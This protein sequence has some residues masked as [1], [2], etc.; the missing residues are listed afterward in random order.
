MGS[1]DVHATAFNNVGWFLPPYVTLGYL[2]NMVNEINTNGESFSQIDLE[3]LLVRIYT[4]GHLSAMVAER[5]PITPYVSEFKEIISESVKAHFLGLDHLAVIGLMPVIEGAGKKLADHR[6][7][8]YSSIRSVFENLAT[9]CKNRSRQNNIGDV[10]E[11]ESMMDSFINFTKDN[12]YIN[13][14]SYLHGDKTNRHGILHGAYSDSDYG[15]PVN[16]YKAIGAVEFLC[17]I[18]A[19]DAS[20][21]WFASDKTENSLKLENYYYM[22][23]LMANARS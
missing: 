22:C 4:K 23:E 3:N 18:S 14:S 7:V 13:S 19:F 17:F 6:Q 20:I 9:D 2:G 16:F 5:Y 21:S 1:L 8:S 11:I 12:L 10:D 15:S